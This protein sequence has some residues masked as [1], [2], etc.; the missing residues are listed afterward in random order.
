VKV[1]W[2]V[3]LMILL[4]VLA[5][6]LVWNLPWRF[7]VVLLIYFI[8]NIAYSWKLKEVIILDVFVI[9]TGFML[10]VLGGAYAIGVN[11][12]SWMILCT[13]FIS[14]FLGFSKRRG[15]IIIMAESN[16]SSGRKV[17]KEYSLE[18]I[19]QMITVVTSGTVISYALYTVSERTKE[20][21]HTENLI[22]TTIFVIFGIF[23]YLYLM[24]RKNLGE[25]PTQIV[26]TDV[27]MIINILLWMASCV[28][29]IYKQEF[30]DYF[31]L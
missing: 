19:D 22:Y 30:L 3:T 26:M 16:L 28:V 13:I 10:R 8:M 18:F 25:S 6:V 14:L 7:Q 17:L 11:V 2:A 1:V 15:E 12:S 4:I 20:T 21:F 31:R 27:P 5:I 24:Y 29:I 9:A 23:R